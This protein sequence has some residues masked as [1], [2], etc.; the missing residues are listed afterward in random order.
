MSNGE[1]ESY[2]ELAKR[3]YAGL[4]EWCNSQT[5]SDLYINSAIVLGSV[6]SRITGSESTSPQQSNP[7]LR[8]TMRSVFAIARENAVF[9][10]RVIPSHTKNSNAPIPSNVIE[11]RFVSRMSLNSLPNNNIYGFHIKRRTSLSF[12]I[13]SRFFSTFRVSRVF[14]QKTS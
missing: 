6:I 1:L 12:R 8:I 11:T 4:I 5:K 9:G 10:L 13:I 2:I 7:P 14:A 3:Y